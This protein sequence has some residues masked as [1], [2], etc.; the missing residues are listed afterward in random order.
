MKV[1]I[2]SH[3]AFLSLICHCIAFGLISSLI[4]CVVNALSHIRAVFYCK[5][6]TAVSTIIKDVS[7]V[8]FDNCVSGDVISL[9]LI[10]I[11]LQLASFIS[12]CGGF[13]LLSIPVL[14]IGYF[15]GVMLFRRVV[16]SLFFYVFFVIK[17]ILK[18]AFVPIGFIFKTMIRLI[19]RCF[20][21]I[22]QRYRAVLIVKYTEKRYKDLEY[23]KQFGLLDPNI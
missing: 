15:A 6:L 3:E 9:I 23:I 10:A 1:V 21:L 18:I 2:Y 17:R 12:N 4:Y 7:I 13:R 8:G 20:M 16:L 5:K 22:K 11:A 14:L 19:K